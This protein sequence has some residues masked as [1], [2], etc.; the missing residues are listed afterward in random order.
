MWDKTTNWELF[1]VLPRHAVFTKAMFISNQ[2]CCILLSKYFHEYIEKLTVEWWLLTFWWSNIIRKHT[3]NELRL[4]ISLKLG[5][6]MVTFVMLMTR[7]QVTL[8]VALTRYRVLLTLRYIEFVTFPHSPSY[9]AFPYYYSCF[10]F[11]YFF[12][13]VISS[14]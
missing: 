11:M 4:I 1:V 5:M 8:L 2:D 10:D 13:I 14:F 7:L 6:C 12:G 3:G 9:L